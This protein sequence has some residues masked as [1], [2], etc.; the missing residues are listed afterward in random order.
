MP[1]DQTK[2]RVFRHPLQP[3][4]NKEKLHRWFQ[5]PTRGWKHGQ[6]S[7]LAS[8]NTNSTTKLCVQ[9]NRKSGSSLS[10]NDRIHQHPSSNTTTRRNFYDHLVKQDHKQRIP[11]SSI[12]CKQRTSLDDADRHKKVATGTIQRGGLGTSGPGHEV[13]IRHV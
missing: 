4:L 5:I 9:Y 8:T 13:N 12:P 1:T 2:H 11:T 7:P 3:L 6:V 10:H